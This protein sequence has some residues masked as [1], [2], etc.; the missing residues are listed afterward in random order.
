MDEER[1]QE[2][3]ESRNKWLKSEAEGFNS[4]IRAIS[5]DCLTLEDS[6]WLRGWLNEKVVQGLDWR[7]LDY[8]AISRFEDLTR[9]F[10]TRDWGVQDISEHPR[11][12][13]GVEELQGA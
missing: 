1:R 10:L 13:L 12:A 4:H 8:G 6:M 3:W 5:D 7:F 2:K 11:V 9:F